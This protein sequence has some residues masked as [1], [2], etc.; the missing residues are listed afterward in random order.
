MNNNSGG[1]SSSTALEPLLTS[2]QYRTGTLF[3]GYLARKPRAG[4]GL[5]QWDTGTR[6]SGEF[7]EC[8]RE[9]HGRLSWPDGSFYEGY[10]HD[11]LREG[12]GIHVWGDTGQV[13]SA[14]A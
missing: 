11:D 2:V 3:K 7:K 9:G 12:H 13:R 8:K 5:F 1:C 14:S 6:Y 10:F 4:R